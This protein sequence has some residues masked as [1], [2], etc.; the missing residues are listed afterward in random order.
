MQRELL[1]VSLLFTALIAAAGSA[2]AEGP[3]CGPRGAIVDQLGSRYQETRRAVGIASNNAVLEI[4]A[5]D[6][7]GS[8]TILVTLPDGQS[9]LL[10]SGESFEALSEPLPTAGK[11]A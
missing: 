2:R 5:S 1:A 7:S 4:F 10:A 8:F 6:D 3:P 9:C 11:G